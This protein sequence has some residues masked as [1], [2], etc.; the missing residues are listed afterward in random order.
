[1]AQRSTMGSITG[2]CQPGRT[3]RLAE[4]IGRAEQRKEEEEEE[5]EVLLRFGEE[6]EGRE[7]SRGNVADATKHPS[8]KA[9]S[10]TSTGTSTW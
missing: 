1:M 6:Q 10:H 8:P 7:V 4:T 3:T 5:E 9:L 2:R